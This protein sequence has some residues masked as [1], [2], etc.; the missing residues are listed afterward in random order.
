MKIFLG[1]LFGYFL[2]FIGTLGLFAPFIQ[3]IVL[4]IVGLSI[5]SLFNEKL[6]GFI[7]NI[8]SRFPSLLKSYR[9]YH[10]KF[11]KFFIKQKKT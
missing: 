8:L 11:S 9:K 2:I 1:K 3:G 7:E 5:V 6:N 4:I 10:N